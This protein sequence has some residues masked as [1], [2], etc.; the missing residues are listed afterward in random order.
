MIMNRAELDKYLANNIVYTG[1][2]L[3]AMSAKDFATLNEA[4]KKKV[5]E[6]AKRGREESAMKGSLADM[7]AKAKSLGYDVA[8]NVNKKTNEIEVIL[9]EKGQDVKKN[10][11]KVV[12]EAPTFKLSIGEGTRGGKGKMAAPKSYAPH[13]SKSGKGTVLLT[14]VEETINSVT[15]ALSKLDS[16]K[17]RPDK[18]Y[19]KHEVKKA[20]R[21]AEQ[22]IV[23]T[24]GYSVV[25]EDKFMEEMKKE[26]SN[27]RGQ[28]VRTSMR[29]GG[30]IGEVIKKSNFT[31]NITAAQRLTQDELKALNQKADA[32]VTKYLAIYAQEGEKAADNYFKATKVL[33][34]DFKLSEDDI[35]AQLEA[36]KSGFGD[37]LYLPSS[38]GL[39][40]D[41]ALNTKKFSYVGDRDLAFRPSTRTG[42]HTSQTRNYLERSQRAKSR[43]KKR[44]TERFIP[45]VDK[46]D[47]SYYKEM[48]HQLY[49]RGLVSGG[50]KDGIEY[51]PQML[52]TKAYE[53]A[54]AAYIE[55]KVKKL[56]ESK[57]YNKASDA[58]KAKME[59]ELRENIQKSL[60]TIAQLGIMEDAGL[61][62]ESAAREFESSRMVTTTIS[63][64]EY[65]KLQKE[66]KEKYEKLSEKAKKAVNLS[67]F[68]D[69]FI[70]KKALK[71]SKLSD[72]DIFRNGAEG[73]F[74]ISATETVG[75]NRA[76]LLSRYTGARETDVAV[77]DF[78]FNRMAK[79]L[80][81]EGADI[82][83]AA[84]K[85]KAEEIPG[86]FQGLLGA[87][88]SQR[89]AGK[90][91]DEIEKT[92]K[93]TVAALNS[94]GFKASLGENGEIF[95]D[96]S[97]EAVSQIKWDKALGYLESLNILKQIDGG[98]E[99]VNPATIIEDVINQAD[100]YDPSKKVKTSPKEYSSV[101][102]DI[103]EAMAASGDKSK[104]KSLAADVDR[105]YDPTT[106][107]FGAE[108]K[109]AS[110]DIDAILNK[111]TGSIV[112]TYQTAI[113]GKDRIKDVASL[114]RKSYNQQTGK[115]KKKK[116]SHYIISVGRGSGYT[117]DASQ[118]EM[119]AINYQE[120]GGLLTREDYEN[121]VLGTIDK[122]KS[123]ILSKDPTASVDV[124]IDP[125]TDFG[126]GMSFD[127]ENAS[128]G[129]TGRF[130]V[131]PNVEIDTVQKDGETLYS[132]PSYNKE[133]HSLIGSIKSGQGDSGKTA[134]E[135]NKKM[136]DAAHSS[137]GTLWQKA[138]TKR[139]GGSTSGHITGISQDAIDKALA[140][141]DIEKAKRLASDIWV[142]EKAM[143]EMLSSKTPYTS[144]DGVYNVSEHQNFLTEAVK[145]LYKDE[146]GGILDGLSGSDDEKNKIL[147][148]AIAQRIADDKFTGAKE[149][150]AGI[151]NRFPSIAQL[152][153][154]FSSYHVSSQ[155]QG[156]DI[157]VGAAIAK[158]VN[159]DYD[160]DTL[161]LV[162]GLMSSG[163]SF[164][165]ADE[166]VERQREKNLNL[167]KQMFSKG[168]GEPLDKT[169]ATL[170]DAQKL[171]DPKY[172]GLSALAA[173]FNKPYTGMFSNISTRIREGLKFTGFD[174]IDE[175][176]NP[177]ELSSVNDYIDVIR[178]KLVAGVGQILE[179]D[180]ISSK[181]V[182]K[183]LDEARKAK[184]RDLTSEEEEAEQLKV[185][186]EFEDLYN[187]MRD[188][189]SSY[190]DII[191]RMSEMGLFGSDV[192]Q[193]S[194]TL[195]S[196]ILGLLKGVSGEDR[197]IILSRLGISE[198][199]LT[200]GALSS[201]VYKN[202]G[203]A[204]ENQLI[205]PTTGKRLK[206]FAG[207]YGTGLATSRSF[208]PYMKQDTYELLRFLKSLEDV[209]SVLKKTGEIIDENGN[210]FNQ[211]GE[212]IKEAKS[213]L[214]AEA[215]QESAK[216]VIAAKEG[217]TI[218]RNV[219]IYQKLSEK[220][221]TA[222]S[223]YNEIN[224]LS[225]SELKS[226]LL[227]YGG[228]QTTGIDEKTLNSVY[229]KIKAG[230]TFTKA[231]L[232]TQFGVEDEKAL[233][234]L[235]LGNL[236]TV[237]GNYIHNLSQGD[238]KG[239]RKE[240]LKLQKMFG[241]LGY[242]DEQIASTFDT[243][244][245]GAK[246]VRAI[247][248][249]YGRSLGSEI[250]FIGMTSDGQYV[251][252]ARGD[253]FFVGERA[254][255][256]YDKD[257]KDPNQKKM[258]RVFTAVD[259]KTHTSGKLEDSDIVQGVIY[260]TFLEDLQTRLKSIKGDVD[261][262]SFRAEVSK[263]MK[264]TSKTEEREALLAKITPD[265]IKNLKE[266]DVVQTEII[267]VNPSIG[268]AQAYSVGADKDKFKVA[269]DII[270]SG[271]TSPLTSEEKT[272]VKSVAKKR[273]DARYFKPGEQQE[274]I[275]SI[276]D[277]LKQSGGVTAE[278]KNE[279]QKEY[280]TLVS[281]EF[282][283]KK[284]IAALDKERW[285]L[286][287]IE[288]KKST[289]YTVQNLDAEKQWRQ[290]ELKR[291]QDRKAELEGLGA[292][293]S[294]ATTASNEEKMTAYLTRLG[295]GADGK[296]ALTPE[297]QADYWSQY[298][299]A[300]DKQA[301]AE[302]EIFG[303]RNKAQTSYGTE[304]NLLY[305]IADEKEKALVT[306]KANVAMI[307]KIVGKLDPT[308]LANIKEQVALNQQLYKLQALKQTRGAT[309]IWDVM[310]NDIRRATMR[311]ADFGIAAKVL[312]KIPQ[313]IQKVIQYTKELDAAMTN[314]RI[315]GGYNEEQ[316]RSL[317]RSYTELGE[318]L[319]AT[320]VEVATAAN[321][322][323]RQGYEASEQLE[324]LISASTKLSKLGMISAS[325]ATTALTAALKSF[326]LTAE[327]AIKVVDKLTKVDQL[328]AV[329]AGGISTALQK[330]ATSAKL[331]GM[332]MDELI[333][334][335]SV[336]GEVTQQ[337]MDTVG[338]AMK[339]IL[340]RYGNVK[341]SVFTQMG[342]ND[343]GETSE[344]INDIEKVL[345][346]LGI[347]MRS[348]S[349]E[350]RDI[351]DV[352]DEVNEKWDTYDTVTK[353]ALAT[354]F[355]GTR[356]RENFLVLMEN[357]SHV[358][359]LT[360]E[361]AN[362]AGTADEKYS[363]YMD[364]MEAA[365][366]R[367]QNAWEGFTQS[368]ETSTVMKFL[369]NAAALLVENADKFKYILTVF[370]AAS[371]VKIFDFFT[372]K[373]ETGG[374]KGLVANI[375]FIGRG[376]KTNNIL[377]SIDKK[378]GIIQGEVQKDKS[379]MTKNGGLISRIVT[380]FSEYGRTKRF[381][382]GTTSDVADIIAREAGFNPDL[383]SYG[384]YKNYL[385]VAE[386]EKRK[387]QE[388]LAKSWKQR[389][390]AF[391]QTAA[392]SG[393]ATLATQLM[394]TKQVSGYGQ[395]VEE[396]G[397][398]EALRTGLATA[399]SIAGAAS[400]LI[401]VVGPMIAPIISSL[402]SIA[403]EGLAG[404]ISK[405]FHKDELQMKQRVADAKDNL[406]ALTSIN[407]SVSENSSLM[408]ETFLDSSGVKNLSKY[409]DE[410]SEKL[411]ELSN[412]ALSEFLSTVSTSTEKFK[413]IS[414]LSNYI[415]EANAEERKEIQQRIEVATAK[416]QLKQTIASQEEERYKVTQTQNK[417]ISPNYLNISYKDAAW[418]TPRY[419]P[420]FEALQKYTDLSDTTGFE[421]GAHQA[422]DFSI[423]GRTAREQLSNLQNLI[424]EV[425]QS[426]DKAN[427]EFSASYIKKLLKQLEDYEKELQDAVKAQDKLDAA[428]IKSRVQVAFFQANLSDL[429][430][431]ELQN[432]TI[433][434]VAG[435]VVEALE[436][437]GVA[438]R[439]LSGTI[440]D[441]YLTQIKLAIKSDEDLYS[442]LQTDT[443]S[444]GKLM[445]VRSKF[446][447][448][449]GENYDKVRED[450]DKGKLDHLS[451][452]LKGL[453]YSADPERI[454]QF[455]QAWHIATSE[456]ENFAKRF[457]NLN[458]ATGLM[459]VDEVKDK[460][461]KIAEIFS[462]I[463]HDR[464]L[465][466]EQFENILKN[467]PEYL[468]K[469][470]DYE[471]LMGSLISSIGEESAE[472]Y[473]NA[474]FSDVMS[475]A[476]YFAEFKKTLNEEDVKTIEEAGAKS[477]EDIY[478]LAQGK[479]ELRGITEALDEYLNKVI[480][481][482]NES[483]LK[484]FMIELKSGLLDEEINNLNEQ[485]DALSKINDERK[486]EIEYIKA[487]YALEDARKEKKRVF[488]AG[489]G[490][491]FESDEAA[492]SEAKEKVDSLDLERQ[493]ESL[494]YQID[495]LEQQKEILEAI[496]NNEQLKK[497][498]EA[499]GANGIS[500]DTADIAMML[501][502]S[503]KLDL[504]GRTKGYK[505]ALSEK[506]KDL[507]KNVDTAFQTYQTALDEFTKGDKNGRKWED[508]NQAERENKLDNLSIL[509]SDYQKA[510][511][512][513]QSFGVKNM[514]RW[515]E[516]GKI[517]SNAAK[518]DKYSIDRIVVNGLGRH[519]LDWFNDDIKLR[520]GDKEFAAEL[521][522][523]NMTVTQKELNEA[524]GQAPA[525]GD[526]FS[527]KGKYYVYRGDEWW[528]VLKDK[529]GVGFYEY[530]AGTS[531]NAS[532]TTSFP[533]G[534]TLI[535][536][537][538]TEAVITPGG[539][540]T[541]LP[542][543]TGIV[544][545]DIT[546]NVWALGEVAPTLIARLGSLTQKP[547]AGNGA[548]TTYEE[549]QYIDN[550]TMN[551]YPAKGD[552]FNKILEQARAQVRLTRRNN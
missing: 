246:N 97:D 101:K 36:V 329:S 319:G 407:N 544:P 497:I 257:S 278:Q 374:W 239:A 109:K 496:K 279:S 155:L 166:M 260:K 69:R 506:A 477:F 235:F 381:T 440:K 3:E 86:Y 450:L 532:G 361:S 134:Q 301:R 192:T 266:S 274:G 24:E 188:P 104:F 483:P 363:A 348:S 312:N 19:V 119:A 167:Y 515:S 185:L 464:T 90:N 252:N 150:L 60:P 242:S 501:A 436:K 44:A 21:L 458:T 133:I 230:K 433:D 372:N 250:P 281:E 321:E 531:A 351:T 157:M 45:D 227:P 152:S 327:D 132:L 486:K 43:V 510:Y 468:N 545:A 336:I 546:R 359:E 344:N 76:K 408:E 51:T 350:L 103:A 1:E 88:I 181:K 271:D 421:A 261:I 516:D 216:V 309:S 206:I 505:T 418:S 417:Q 120:G 245:A 240:K 285:K 142:S 38:F 426:I 548:N 50:T 533:G 272:S 503:L 345:S 335:V 207:E 254:N 328:A 457:P 466:I 99:F 349:T 401:P 159:G 353:N 253:E 77:P 283:L 13:V 158:F 151:M 65:D 102:R 280:N 551:V 144:A 528:E 500:T 474:L 248:K 42:R 234:S 355:G 509:Y 428:L 164:E 187:M 141:G 135:L 317:M 534:Q 237:R 175:Q 460:Y 423:K 316:A 308:R 489:V 294:K 367:L 547:L 541:A 186:Q 47:T 380:G 315:V 53:D 465:S 419:A 174:V 413:T 291:M 201:D 72:V 480:E 352:L 326:N 387:A 303:I 33:K 445:E 147:S 439:D 203:N 17:T 23:T 299:R 400:A 136:F 322:W 200:K 177:R 35:K 434:G 145:H 224:R 519:F 214:A 362:A 414:D 390:T 384:E 232:A 331:A 341:A 130:L 198:D 52:V 346:K 529:G 360:E 452:D 137:K 27:A 122:V 282:K 406:K 451:D 391:A 476:N 386:I 354:A 342:L 288:G 473:K 307:E 41:N 70:A 56:K 371:S 310:A 126:F 455:A 161:Q 412:D 241:V 244:K 105:M 385:N 337:S 415:L 251:V 28:F 430:Q 293:E 550:L 481:V 524:Y 513:A 393:I 364:S 210:K 314:I 55:E 259:Y 289:D 49:K 115:M 297:E 20:Q 146:A 298:E 521:S 178:G 456:V 286:T 149:G 485:K 228:E 369:T 176:G 25:D 39:S 540:L 170:T 11:E 66:A 320:T 258:Q 383:M 382:K 29:V 522:N 40:G 114:K 80:K 356:M 15:D 511:D 403:G 427:A 338:H 67:D 304:K 143:M 32:V 118:L 153:A 221:K 490:W 530:M 171:S 2:Y 111:K 247:T 325:E 100:T 160:G 125:G 123:E 444:I 394:T 493:Q 156:K 432:L 236:S 373:G 405:W 197:N 459:S 183:R 343:D 131:L 396:T 107:A 162:L 18:G 527:H 368:L 410:L 204:L 196:N 63:E 71:R 205:D 431:S 193:I 61:M 116:G 498:E 357:W 492:I 454:K 379:E 231:E 94:I 268:S 491:T 267:V 442:Q 169:V 539:T 213:S 173:K 523:S 202:A 484:N 4:A 449:F 26:T 416:E 10:Y 226:R 59:E 512:T 292:V 526:V 209:N 332:S 48:G 180:S 429:T 479:K 75:G 112:K 225:T 323:L 189:K 91:Q 129:A 73:A 398:D 57:K 215:G 128:E 535:N 87:S 508:W 437:D 518:S 212:R 194:S 478:Q 388:T 446:V 89:T 270:L 172:M 365:T 79:E 269:R 74:S 334:S 95:I 223:N 12:A 305:Q 300:L 37:F 34:D 249:Q 82:I 284:E 536:E 139:Q 339:S 113:S 191:G 62:S 392:V 256:F 441:D 313:D 318:T 5:Q 22:S 14:Q 549:G 425:R 375:P 58:R 461:T 9:V 409:V 93:D 106:G 96:N 255:P 447:Q 31:K 453:I 46:A 295:V 243:Y 389:K 138:H 190:S 16:R 277:K 395:T 377:E 399:G 525:K 306:D 98:F 127:G 276:E 482:E 140:E 443:K 64:N 148:R 163:K 347:R 263:G 471:G 494:Q 264:Y 420:Y 154:V 311:I 463:S 195:S 330:S 85:F 488:R 370:A 287:D 83:S 358:K 220:L 340:A 168:K 411:G 81:I 495:S 520:V 179:Q 182:E 470:G 467:Y 117:I 265:L 275:G 211:Y 217:K 448:Q 124:M 30:L 68:T 422:D 184:G 302:E 219:D 424:E 507:E 435:K 108:A 273:T 54:A 366:K 290:D 208:T 475:S 552:D 537:L 543:K 469:I 517:I 84:K 402:G 324:E 376:T 502:Q 8:Y 262:D 78:I 199:D 218:E 438:V 296:M 92:L 538:G 165:E 404:L 487:K 462:D 504:G 121:T 233:N 222:G 238:V 7:E 333:G 397:G 378:V 542:S 6:M 110:V 229:R 472:A 499:L 514:E